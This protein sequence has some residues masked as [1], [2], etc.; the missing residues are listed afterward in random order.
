MRIMLC[1]KV[2]CSWKSSGHAG[3]KHAW[4]SN[5]L[6]PRFTPF[7]TRCTLKSGE[8]FQIC[9]EASVHGPEVHNQ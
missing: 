7:G 8:V 3:T 5:P 6:L 2:A 1:E 9:E 4:F